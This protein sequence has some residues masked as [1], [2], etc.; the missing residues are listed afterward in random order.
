MKKTKKRKKIEKGE[1][2]YF[3]SEKKRRLIL[4]CLL[5]TSDAADEL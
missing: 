1:F 3:K 5:Y 2:G 4:T